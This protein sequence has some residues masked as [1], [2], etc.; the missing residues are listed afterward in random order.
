MIENHY[1]IWIASRAMKIQMWLRNMMYNIVY[2]C[3]SSRTQSVGKFL[4]ENIG[5]IDFWQK[6]SPIIFADF[7]HW[8]R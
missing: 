8:Y 7:M 1:R 2:N 5:R 6:F 4:L 3:V